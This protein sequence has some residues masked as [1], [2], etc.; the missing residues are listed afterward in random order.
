MNKN[1]QIRKGDPPSVVTRKIAS[2]PGGDA[3]SYGVPGTAYRTPGR[4]SDASEGAGFPPTTPKVL[5]IR[6]E[7]SPGVY[8]TFAA[9]VVEVSGALMYEETAGEDRGHLSFSVFGDPYLVS[10]MR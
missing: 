6:V 5:G 3:P 7:T 2:R 10:G 4:P 1:R 9:E 8:R